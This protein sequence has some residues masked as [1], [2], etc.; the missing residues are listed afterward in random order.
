MRR[1]IAFLM[2][3]VLLFTL[4]ACGSKQNG[5]EDSS[6]TDSAKEIT[7]AASTQADSNETVESDA[8]KAQYQQALQNL[9]DKGMPISGA[10]VYDVDADGIPSVALSVTKYALHPLPEYLLNY[11]NGHLIEKDDI[12]LDGTG[13][14]INNQALFG[15]GTDNLIV[16]VQGMTSG[17]WADNNTKVFTVSPQGDAY[18]T[19]EEFSIDTTEME[20]EG[21]RRYA[22]DPNVDVSDFIARITEETDQRVA[23]YAPDGKFYDYAE[24]MTWF[25][26][27]EDDDTAKQMRDAVA[28]LE[29]ALGITLTLDESLYADVY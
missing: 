20:E 29:D 11:K 17:T 23:K 22:A 27:L 18:V 10:W 21:E 5:S 15:N 6:P 19:V 14:S 24:E 13:G 26:N 4:C 7:E 16:R 12:E 28:Y 1:W 25:S 2:T 3:S 8:W 9:L